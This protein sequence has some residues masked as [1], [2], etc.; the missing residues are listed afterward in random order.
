V[1]TGTIK[2]ALRDIRELPAPVRSWRV[3]SGPD[4]TG[5]DAVWVWV[6]LDDEDLD[7]D[8]R[9]RLRDLV[10]DVV[11]QLDAAAPPWVYVRFRGASE[12]Q[13]V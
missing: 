12:A 4:A 1:T 2:S 6:T 5:D 7:V 3:E 11:R 13:G 8:T 9:S 10:W